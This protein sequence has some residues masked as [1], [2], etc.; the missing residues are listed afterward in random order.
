LSLLFSCFS[1]SLIYI[2]LC[3]IF[4]HYPYLFPHVAY[5]ISNRLPFIRFS[6]FYIAFL[7]DENAGLF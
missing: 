6:L 1:L 5:L 2:F 7:A 4:F 3:H